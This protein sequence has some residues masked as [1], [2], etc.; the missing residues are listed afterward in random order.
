M[1][2]VSKIRASN[3]F[4]ASDFVIRV[5]NIRVS[6]PRLLRLKLAAA[7]VLEWITLHD[8]H[9][10]CRASIIIFGQGRRDLLERGAIVI[11]QP[12]TERVR[13]QAR[14]EVF[15]EG[16]MLG[17]QN[18][19]QLRSAAQIYGPFQLQGSNEIIRQLLFIWSAGKYK[20]RLWESQ[21]YLLHN[22]HIILFRPF[23][24]G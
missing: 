23:T 11:F 13:Q 18:I 12:A 14:T 17:H 6:L 24:Q 10:Q 15:D 4:R 19:F 1:T 3:L 22:P 5:S 2:E 21:F 16:V 8:L 9:D 7:P 20:F